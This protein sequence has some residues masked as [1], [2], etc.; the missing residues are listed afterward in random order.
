MI[1][2][3]LRIVDKDPRD[4]VKVISTKVFDGLNIDINANMIL[5]DMDRDNILKV[6]DILMKIYGQDYEVQII[7]DMDEAIVNTA[8]L[9]QVKNY[10]LNRNGI[11]F[12]PKIDKKMKRIYDF[13]DIMGIMKILR[14]DGGCP[15]DRKQDHKSIRQSIIEEAY[16]VVDAID[17]G[18]KEGIKEELGD[19]L[20]QVVFHSQIAY[21]NGDFYPLDV[22]SALANKLIYRHPHIFSQKSVENTKEVVYNWNKLKYENRQITTLAGKLKDI[23]KLPALM[24]SYKAQE[25]A[26]DIGFDW[27]DISGAVDKVYEELAEVMAVINIDADK[28]EEE[29]GDLLFAIVNLARFLEINPEIALNR[30]INKFIYRLEKVEEKAFN[31]DKNLEDMSLEEMDHLWNQ[32][33]NEEKHG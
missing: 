10:G 2:K 21:E 27:D 17:H 14:G 25:K 12:I 4:G 18:D 7:L 1:D 15:W 16:E 9:K 31:L 33:K 22:T 32:V 6:R 30:T 28:T 24:H 3:I 19:L 13:T 20:L 5:L 29:L 11:I 23:P 26:A 8:P